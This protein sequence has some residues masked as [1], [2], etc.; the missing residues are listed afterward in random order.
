MAAAL[1]ATQGW[2][3]GLPLILL[4]GGGY[5]FVASYANLTEQAEAAREQSRTLLVDLEAAY[6][7]LATSAA[8]AEELAVLEERQ[9]LARELHDSVTQSLYGLTLSA[10][11]ASR[12]LGQGRPDDAAAQVRDVRETAQQALGEL[13][14]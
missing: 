2:V 1:V 11:T 4:Y 5:F 13:R 7:R 10:E 12:A 9:R 14:L 3:D 8:Q 6:R